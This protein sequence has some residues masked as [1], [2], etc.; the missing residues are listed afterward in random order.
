MPVPTKIHGLLKA[1]EK[2]MKAKLQEIV[3]SEAVGGITVA[4]DGWSNAKVRKHVK[5]HSDMTLYC[6]ATDICQLC[7][8]RVCGCLL[9]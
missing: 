9:R 1:G 4:T 8:R 2:I 7:L 6:S 5:C 3:T